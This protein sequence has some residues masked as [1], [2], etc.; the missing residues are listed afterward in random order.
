MVTTAIFKVGSIA[1]VALL[2]AAYELFKNEN[3]KS[4]ENIRSIKTNGQLNASVDACIDAAGLEF[5]VDIKKSL[6]AAASFGKV[7]LLFL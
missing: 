5:S 4:D 1:P 2:V 7:K 6:M 3:P